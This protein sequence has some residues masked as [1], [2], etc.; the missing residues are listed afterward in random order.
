VIYDEGATLMET[1][2]AMEDL[3]FRGIC[4]AIGLSDVGLDNLRE[5]FGQA[6]VKPSVVQIESHPYLP[7]LRFWSSARPMD[8]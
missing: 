4:W 8:A 5:V 6:R 2:R 7:E 3:V 1:W